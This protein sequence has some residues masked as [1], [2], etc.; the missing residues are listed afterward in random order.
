MGKFRKKPV[1]PLVEQ[2]LPAAPD[3]TCLKD[4]LAHIVGDVAGE[5]L[6]DEG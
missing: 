6:E 1:V 5:P 4:G 2:H 3:V